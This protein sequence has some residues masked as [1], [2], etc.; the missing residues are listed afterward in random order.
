METVLLDFNRIKIL[1]HDDKERVFE[2]L[3]DMRKL[4]LRRT[5]WHPKLEIEGPDEEIEKYIDYY[6]MGA[7]LYMDARDR[8]WDTYTKLRDMYNKVLTKR[9]GW[10]Y[11]TFIDKLQEEIGPA[12]YEEGLALPGFHIYG[13]H[14]APK[15]RKHHRCLHYDGQW[16]WGAKYFKE[17]YKE[18][19]WR[20]QL[21]YTFCIK[22]PHN[23]TAIALWD[24]PGSHQRKARELQLQDYHSIIDRYQTLDYVKE[25][26]RNKVIE[27]PWKFD[28]FDDDGPLEKYIPYVIPHLEG[29]SFWYYGMVMHQ[30]ILGDSFLAGDYR[31]TF[32]G[33]ALKC[34]GKWRLFW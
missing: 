33:H 23:G 29:H 6:T 3:L 2:E 20:N 31:I 34:D 21:S 12:E 15:N 8:G 19:D 24:L 22:V 7:T 28:L 32:Q 16:F 30:M 13:F 5:N 11:D 4:W 1:E 25:I 27:D 10:L 9:L 26:K 14:D 18:I 17:K